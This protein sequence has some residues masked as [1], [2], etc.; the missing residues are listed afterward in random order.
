METLKLQVDNLKCGGCANTIKNGLRQL[1]GIKE[2]LVNPEEQW[3]EITSERAIDQ[4]AVLNKLRAMGYPKTG[5][6]EGL[7]KLGR[8]LQSYVSCA[9]GRLEGEDKN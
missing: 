5:T 2:V 6:T 3:V 8:H 9:I 7:E 1:E 4:E